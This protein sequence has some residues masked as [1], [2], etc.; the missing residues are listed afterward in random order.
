MGV[1]Q[2]G[3]DH[4]CC[5]RDDDRCIFNCDEGNPAEYELMCV[6]P[7]P[8]GKQWLEFVD[9]VATIELESEDLSNHMCLYALELTDHDLW[10]VTIKLEEPGIDQLNICL[11]KI[12]DEGA[13]SYEAKL[14]VKDGF[15]MGVLEDDSYMLLKM[16]F[17]EDLWS[18]A[19]PLNH[20]Q[21]KITIEDISPTWGIGFEDLNKSG[22]IWAV[23]ILATLAV[24][25]MLC[26]VWQE[27]PVFKRFRRRFIPKCCKKK[28][29]QS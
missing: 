3:D 16:Y 20:G 28:R 13:R 7:D 5:E 21:I 12:N 9:K 2:Q 23:A 18:L 8:C 10:Q 15:I 14:C 26:R 29:E 6:S 25:F 27:E 11:E 1:C 17:N 22:G 24:L 19:T 4:V